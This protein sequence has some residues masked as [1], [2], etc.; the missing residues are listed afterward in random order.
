[1]LGLKIVVGV[2]PISEIGRVCNHHIPKGGFLD[3]VH[4]GISEGES[5]SSFLLSV[6]PIVVKSPQSDECSFSLGERCEI[7]EA[8]SEHE[9]ND[10]CNPY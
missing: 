1:M 10:K 9:C 6:L 8:D 5:L 2:L 4:L 7:F 3:A